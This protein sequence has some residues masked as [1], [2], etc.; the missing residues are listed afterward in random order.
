MRD[1]R[2]DRG[3]DQHQVGRAG[4]HLLRRAHRRGRRGDADGV[5]LVVPAL[6]HCG[7]QPLPDARR[8]R[9]GGAGDSGEDHGHE[10]IRVREAAARFR[11]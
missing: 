4:D 10:D 2:R 1:G 8:V 6:D 5:L 9:L 3:H 11:S 7:N